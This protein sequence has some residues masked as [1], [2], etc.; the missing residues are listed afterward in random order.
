MKWILPRQ[1]GTVVLTESIS[2]DFMRKI[3]VP[4]L[5]L[6]IIIL[7]GCK[8]TVYVKNLPSD[9]VVTQEEEKNEP[10]EKQ[11]V[12]EPE[13]DA[14]VKVTDYIPDIIV[15]LKYATTDNFTGVVIYDDN[16]AYLRYGT[17][18]KLSSAQ[19]KLREMGYCIKIWDAYR[20]VEAQFKLWEIC[21]DPTFVANPNKGYSSHSR[22][23]TVDITVTDLSGKE[24]L[25]PS[26]FDEFGSVADRDYSDVSEKAGDNALMLEKAMEDCGFKGYIKEWWHYSDSV[27]YP[28]VNEQ[29]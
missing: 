17:V 25:M 3:I 15:E 2:G 29:E 1:S 11:P 12:P 21:P 18:K 14:L 24:I 10:T 8:E 6:A 27:E 19:E 20:P 16:T 13:D 9:P 26:G 7:S 4:I 5:L 28:V 22:G 23:N